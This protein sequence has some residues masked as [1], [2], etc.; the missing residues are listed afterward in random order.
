MGRRSRLLYRHIPGQCLWRG[1]SGTLLRYLGNVHIQVVGF[2]SGASLH[3]TLLDLLP[4]RHA[5]LWM[6][7]RHVTDDKHVGLS[8]ASQVF[9]YCLWGA[10]PIAAVIKGPGAA[11]GAV[12]G[13]ATRE[14]DGS[15]RI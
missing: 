9:Y 15:T 1:A 7:E 12:S 10:L 8:D 6:D 14:L 2:E 11:E 4:N 3:T 13:T 5:V